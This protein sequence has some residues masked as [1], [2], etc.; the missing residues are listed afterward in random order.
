M[1]STLFLLCEILGLPRSSL[2][3]L[4]EDIGSGVF[5]TFP[6]N[7]MCFADIETNISWSFFC[8]LLYA[9]IEKQLVYFYFFSISLNT[10]YMYLQIILASI[11]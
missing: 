1:Q 9:S 4:V 10:I 5:M 6:K 8:D 3:P 2:V 7:C 11:R